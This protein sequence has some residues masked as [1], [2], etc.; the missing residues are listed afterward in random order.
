MATLQTTKRTFLKGLATVPI[1]LST[2]R[3]NV[4]DAALLN[5][6]FDTGRELFATLNAEFEAYWQ[7]ENGQRISIDQSHAASSKQA[8]AIMQGLRADVVTFSQELDVQVLADRGLISRDWQSAYPYSASPFYTLPVF[9]VREE[10]P[11]AIQDWSD[12]AR[13]DVAVVMPN[14]RTSGAARYIYLSAYAYAERNF[15]GDQAAMANFLAALFENVTVFDT[16]ARG[17]TTTFVERGLGDVLVTYEFEAANIQK[18]MIQ[19]VFETVMPSVSIAADI[20]VAVL[21]RTLQDERKARAAEAYLA[22]LFSNAAQ[23]I[24]ADLNYRV[25]DERVM[26]AN[27][28][29]FRNV[30]LLTV[31]S[32]FGGW[33]AAQQKHFSETGTL[34]RLFS[35]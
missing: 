22:F 27:T 34:S 16:G 19:S 6:S 7:R 31:E 10:N 11:K 17:S 26:S 8:R 33:R 2:S 21:S 28:D 24:A 18:D 13:E 25:R 1:V 5:V 29:H 35:L 23:N 20:K 32:A 3:A 14:P 4:A 9:K 30:A 15:S 12:L